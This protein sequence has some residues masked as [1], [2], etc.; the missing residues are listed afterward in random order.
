MKD[1]ILLTF[2]FGAGVLA[3]TAFGAKA[4]AFLIGLLD[5]LV[6]KIEGR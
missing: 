4:K 6:V 1:A 2:G 5:K 3:T